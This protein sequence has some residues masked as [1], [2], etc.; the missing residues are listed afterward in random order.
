MNNNAGSFFCQPTK[1]NKLS[2]LGIVLLLIFSCSLEAKELWNGGFS[3]SDTAFSGDTGLGYGEIAD[4]RLVYHPFKNSA[5][6]PE[7]S[8]GFQFS[9]SPYHEDAAGFVAGILLPVTVFEKHPFNWLMDQ[10]EWMV[11]AIKASARISATDYTNIRYL[12]G[13]EPLRWITGDMSLALFGMEAVL[14][15]ERGFEGF[16]ITLFSYRYL[17]W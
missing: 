12:L 9:F 2:L 15:V 16:G 8:C 7:F 14:S 5:L 1:A 17:L 11:P 3:L 10:E 6:A 13:I 4:L